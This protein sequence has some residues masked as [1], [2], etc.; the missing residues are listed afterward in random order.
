VDFPDDRRNEVSEYLLNKYGVNSVAHIITFQRMK[1]KMAIRDTGRIL[2]MN[3]NIINNISK[4]FSMEFEE[5]IDAAINSIPSLKEAQKNYP[6]LFDISKKL[7]G[8]PRQQGL[9]AAGIVL[10]N[11]MDEVV[12]TISS[13][14]GINSTQ[15]SMEYLEPLG[16]IKVDLLGLSN[17]SVIQDI[18]KLI[19]KNKGEE[20]VL[21]K[22][23]LQDQKIFSQLASGD[24]IGIFQLESSGMTK[25]VRDI[26]PKS[27]ED[28]SVISALYRPG[29]QEY[30]PTYLKNKADPQS[31][32]YVS[33]DL[34]TI[35]ESTY[36][37][38][39]YQEQLMEIIKKVCNFSLAK[40]DVFRRIISKK[41]IEML[42]ELEKEFIDAALANNYKIE[43]AN[44]I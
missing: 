2:N 1:A 20:V 10:T 27:I 7:I 17:L 36:N 41:K 4:M 9:H 34:K 31:I 16:L 40:A 30:I 12:P 13:T 38:V 28:I 21:D 22:I 32:K 24:T 11:K 8:F 37:I 6:E 18:I 3:I 35:L 14:D 26:K 5:D 42:P 33:D 39:V 23:N 15:Y 25:T 44:N 19:R 43:D 29:P